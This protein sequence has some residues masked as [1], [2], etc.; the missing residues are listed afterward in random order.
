MG[1]YGRLADTIGNPL[2]LIDRV[3]V[4]EPEEAAE[5]PILGLDQGKH[6]VLNR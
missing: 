2:R 4:R 1:R 3:A 6:A 5:S